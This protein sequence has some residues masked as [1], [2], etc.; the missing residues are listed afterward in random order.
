MEIE[1]TEE[2][3]RKFDYKYHRDANELLVE[4]ELSH[5]IS[6]DFSNPD[7]IKITDKLTRWNFLTGIINLSLKNALILN[8]MLGILLGVTITS[9]DYKIGLFIFLA[10]MVWVLSWATFYLSKSQSL[11]YFLINWNKQYA[12]SNQSEKV[13]N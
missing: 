10:W 8:V 11:R 12:Y 4:M 3:L 2:F 9:F 1:N 7:N 6:I 5:R 13:I